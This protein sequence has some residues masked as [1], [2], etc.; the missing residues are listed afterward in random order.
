MGRYQ[1][2]SG[3]A[4]AAA[5]RVRRPGARAFKS[6]G[7]GRGFNPTTTIDGPTVG[8]RDG[9]CG[10]R[11][12]SP[13][14]ALDRPCASQGAWRVEGGTQVSFTVHSNRVFAEPG[15]RTVL[16]HSDGVL[17]VHTGSQGRLTVPLGD[18]GPF[19]GSLRHAKR[20]KA[21]TLSCRPNRALSDGSNGT[22]RMTDGKH[23]SDDD[24]VM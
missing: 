1:G 24:A 15:W 2:T 8:G 14:A 20:R 7:T 6:P 12:T 22:T 4:W 9:T 23:D 3:A 5:G 17:T 19:I 10:T 11:Q 21:S 18:R 13:R 16:A